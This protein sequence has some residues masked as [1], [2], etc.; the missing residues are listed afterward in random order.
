MIKRFLQISAVVLA[1]IVLSVWILGTLWQRTDHGKLDFN[2]AVILKIRNALLKNEPLTV[3][4]MRAD[5]DSRAKS[6]QGRPEAVAGIDHINIPG[7]GGRLPLRVYTPAGDGPFPI[8]L[9]F[10]G[11]GWVI[12]NLDTAD[13]ACRLV[14]N[15][16]KCIVIS[17]DYRLSPEHP[18]PAAVEDAYTALQWVAA[19]GRELNGDPARIAVSGSSA[20]GNLSTAV[21]L[22]SRDRKGPRL[23]YQILIYP[24]TDLSSLSTG[25]H[26]FFSEGYGLTR[27][28]M[29]FFLECY[30]PEKKSRT[31]PYA[32]P[33]LA[34]TLAG[35]PPALVITAGFDILRDEGKAYADRLKKAGVKTI[36]SHFPTML[37]GFV[38]MDRIFKEADEAITE[39][40]NALKN[41]F[42]PGLSSPPKDIAKRSSGHI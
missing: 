38:T 16:T 5:S 28:H 13:T 19:H 21:A 37:H 31:H 8:L 20:G 10:H 1:A 23:L 25:S 29:N 15:N 33:L 30:L 9:F 36:H 22:M 6:L 17:V 14:T 34:E 3:A 11:G 7:A 12:G 42:Y 40:S 18:F 35:L 39:V 26:R 2:A 41:T 4:E 27:K 32:S 24:A